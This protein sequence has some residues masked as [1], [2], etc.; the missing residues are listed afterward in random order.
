M[1]LP[2]KYKLLIFDIDGTILDTSEGIIS[3][4]KFAL[5]KNDLSVSNDFDYRVFIGPPVEQSLR[6]Y[7]P[8]LND[9]LNKKVCLDFRNNYKSK[10]LFKA[11]LYPH[12]LD[13]LEKAKKNGME[14][15][16]ATYKRE[17][18]AFEIMSHFGI[19]SFAKIIIGQDFEGKR[20][21]KDIIDIA[22]KSCGHKYNECLMI[23]DTDIDGN[24][25]RDLGIGFLE[26]LFGFGFKK[27]N[28]YFGPS[29]GCI[30]GFNELSF[31]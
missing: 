1:V 3:S 8:F 4:I 10:D 15:A 12:L 2:K 25:A 7:F 5:K 20:N 26:I 24:A 17:D 30:N 27:D 21:K 28:R 13:F 11:K 29:I 31:K 14:I 6:K 19:T 9:E 18:Y 16:V 22:I 23:G